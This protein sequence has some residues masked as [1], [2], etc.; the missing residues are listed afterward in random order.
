MTASREPGVSFPFIL[1]NELG[2]VKMITQG[3]TIKA[4]I[5]TVAH[6]QFWTLQK[7]KALSLR[8]YY[9]V[10]TIGISNAL[11]RLLG[12]PGGASSK[13]PACQ[14]RRHKRHGFNPWVGKIPWR[15]EWQSTLVLLPGES[16]RQRS[17]AVC[18]PWGHK[19]LDT[20]EQL[21]LSLSSVEWQNTWLQSGKLQPLTQTSRER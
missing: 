8:V 20:T 6:F 12:I 10:Q 19:E 13:E 11:L 1:F 18:S 21:T 5:D 7:L 3:D 17:L 4:L 16:H 15:K 9:L 14:Y 2:E